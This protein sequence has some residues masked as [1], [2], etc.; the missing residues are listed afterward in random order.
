MSEP[1]GS[2]RGSS[3]ESIKRIHSEHEKH[4]HYEDTSSPG[5]QLQR[6]HTQSSNI[7]GVLRELK[8]DIVDYNQSYNNQAYYN[9]GRSCVVSN[10]NP[11]TGMGDVYVEQNGKFVKAPRELLENFSFSTREIY[12]EQVGSGFRTPLDR[13]I[14]AE[15]ACSTIS[16]ILLGILAGA[17]LLA[18]IIIIMLVNSRHNLAILD[19]WPFLAIIS[20]VCRTLFFVMLTICL[21]SILD[22]LDMAHAD[23]QHMIDTFQRRKI[24]YVFI[25]YFCAMTAFLI[26]A[27]SND[28]IIYTMITKNPS[29]NANLSQKEKQELADYVNFWKVLTLIYLLLCFLGWLLVTLTRNEDLFYIHLLGMK[30]YE[31]S[32]LPVTNGYE[33]QRNFTTL[34]HISRLPLH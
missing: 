2:R 11:A 25:L 14:V 4:V 1:S 12:L 15:K 10:R 30:K 22:W 24:G 34:D 17:S 9:T 13:A 28:Y 19:L 32:T 20:E 23:L 26:T 31:A 18:F 21:I 7:I 16:R 6:Q 3:A 29:Q 5:L 8:D 27:P 33:N